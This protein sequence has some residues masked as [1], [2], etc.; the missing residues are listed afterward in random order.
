VSERDARG[1]LIV[2]ALRA[3]GIPT[4]V[5]TKT[6]DVER[7]PETVAATSDV[8]ELL[9]HVEAWWVE[10]WLRHPGGVGP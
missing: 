9:E 5:V 7:E 4:A 3:G 1:V 8:G 10:H 2:T 6:H